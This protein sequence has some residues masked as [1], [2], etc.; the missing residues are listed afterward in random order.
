MLQL[1]LNNIVSST[2]RPEVPTKPPLPR[3][4]LNGTRSTVKLKVAPRREEEADPEAKIKKPRRAPRA[5]AEVPQ[6]VRDPEEE[7]SRPTSEL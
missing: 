1:L 3:I 2:P 7:R 5:R 6:R 4:K